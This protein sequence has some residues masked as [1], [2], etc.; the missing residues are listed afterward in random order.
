MSV[1]KLAGLVVAGVLFAAGAAGA[2]Q[3]AF[4]SSSDETSVLGLD[5]GYTRG[6]GE[7][8]TGAVQPVFPT[9]ANEIGS[10]NLPAHYVRPIESMSTSH[11]ESVF[12][13]SSNEV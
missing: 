2:A 6:D 9:S 8:R 3:T 11:T 10:A 12:P 7:I 13:S 1:R 4:P 5:A